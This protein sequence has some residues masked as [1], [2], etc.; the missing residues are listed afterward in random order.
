VFELPLLN[1][2]W[3][4][5]PIFA[6][7]PTTLRSLVFF[8]RHTFA[9]ESK[10]NLACG[11][12]ELI[13]RFVSDNLPERMSPSSESVHIGKRTPLSSDPVALFRNTLIDDLFSVVHFQILDGVCNVY[14]P[15]S[16]HR[17]LEVS[18]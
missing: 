16:G 4:Q 15:H 10:N 12:M 9:I 18:A 7:T 1:F 6:V 8:R 13:E 14:D 17:V 11:C 2:F 3:S 5:E